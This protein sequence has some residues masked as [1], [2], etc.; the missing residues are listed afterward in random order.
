MGAKVPLRLIIQSVMVWLDE[1]TEISRRFCVIASIT[2]I[3]SVMTGNG[4]PGP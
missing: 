1:R 4:R 3:I 2:E